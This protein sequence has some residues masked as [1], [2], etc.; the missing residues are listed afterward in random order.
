MFFFF[1]MYM[2]FKKLI[3]FAIRFSFLFRLGECFLKC[4]LNVVV[5]Q[6]FFTLP[7]FYIF[8]FIFIV[9][10]RVRFSSPPPPLLFLVLNDRVQTSTSYRHYFVFFFSYSWFVFLTMTYSVFSPLFYSASLLFSQCS[11]STFLFFII[12]FALSF[13]FI[14]LSPFHFS[15]FSS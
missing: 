11:H 7:Y 5:I 6:V 4:R 2:Q 13:S 10:F 8:L 9:I 1:F 14:T 12:L 15:L 3:P